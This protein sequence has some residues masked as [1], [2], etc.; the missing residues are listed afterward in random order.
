MRGNGLFFL[1]TMTTLYFDCETYSEADLKTVGTHAYAE[2]P[3][4]E[5][6]VVQWAIDDGEPRVH[7]CTGGPWNEAHYA[8]LRDALTDPTVAIVAHNSAFDRT[9]LRHVWG[10]DIPVERWQD[11][12]V[13]A[14]LHGLPG[15]LDRVGEVLGL[16]VDEAKDKRGRQLIQMFCKPGRKGAA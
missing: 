9:I 16:G 3:S 8:E 12:M 7:D 1:T 4:T 11:T 15:G 10:L 14:L 5:I 2:H 6:I 13:K